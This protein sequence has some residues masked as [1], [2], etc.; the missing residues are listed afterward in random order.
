[1]KEKITA[2]QNHPSVQ[3]ALEA[4]KNNADLTLDQQIELTLIPGYSN[5]EEKK[6]AR[7]KEMI[8]E[9]GYTVVQDEVCNTLAVIEGPKDSP[10]VMVTAHLD[11]VF[12]LDTK[13][14]LKKDGN[15]I[16]IPGI[17]DDTRGCAE[18]LAILRAM[19]E[20]DIKPACTLLIGGDVGEEGVGNFR[21]MR[22]IF[23]TKQTKVDAFLSIDGAGNGL[24]YGAASDVQYRITFRG[25]GGH[26]MG[27]FGLVNPIMCMGRTIAKIAEERVPEDP[28]TIFNISTVEGGTG[29]TSIASECSFTMDVRSADAKVMQ[30]F[31][32]KCLQIAKECADEEYARWEE[33]REMRLRRDGKIRFDAEARIEVSLEEFSGS[34]GGVQDE[35]CE[36][37]TILKNAFEVCGIE[38]QLHG[39]SSTDANIPL[40]LGIPAATISCGG[41]SGGTHDISEW[42]DPTDA[43]KGLQKNLLCV[44]ALTGVEGVCEPLISKTITKE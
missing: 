15:R 20:A 31:T 21:G 9:L 12:P 2:L 41:E 43:W 44:L 17:C 6:A 19:K 5:H 16:C 37:I 1:M 35:N 42:Y 7:F 38:P 36:I 26:S 30:D 32:Q 27:A 39:L 24:T 22:H 13:L 34:I 10:V 11:T 23:N 25:P 3:K 14:E 40:S 33:V 29:V 28:Y 18:V 4:I 8:E